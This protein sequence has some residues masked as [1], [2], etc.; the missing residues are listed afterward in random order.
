LNLCPDAG[1]NQDAMRERLELWGDFEGCMDDLVTKLGESRCNQDFERDFRTSEDLAGAVTKLPL[2]FDSC[3]I[4][5]NFDRVLETAY[6]KCG[7]HT[8]MT[9]AVRF[10][11]TGI[12]VMSGMSDTL[13]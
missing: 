8:T 2:L 9:N 7:N 13:H 5:T 11:L 10:P 12:K 4:T 6:E 1:F 3:A